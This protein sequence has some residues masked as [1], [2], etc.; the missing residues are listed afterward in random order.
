[1]AQNMEIK[2]VVDP[3]L[4]DHFKEGLH[5]QRSEHLPENEIVNIVTHILNDSDFP[6]SA[7]KHG[8]REIRISH[9]IKSFSQPFF[10]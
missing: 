4:L 8:E 6:I 10:D 5:Q 7:H 1:M 3:S 9:H 2:I